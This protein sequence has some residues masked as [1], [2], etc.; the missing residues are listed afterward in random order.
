MNE[1]E[2]SQGI[3]GG[4]FRVDLRQIDDMTRA[5]ARAENVMAYL[6]LARGVNG[7]REHRV[8]THGAHS[9]ATKTGMSNPKAKGALD[10][11]KNPLNEAVPTG[12]IKEYLKPAGAS[13]SVPKKMRPR[14]VMEDPVD[15][16][17]IWLANALTDGI[18]EGKNNPPLMRIYNDVLMGHN[19]SIQEA[20]LDALMVLL[21]LY[22]H[23]DLEA[24][25]G[26]NPRAGIYRTWKSAENSDGERTTDLDDKGS[27]A[28]FEIAGEF[29]SVFTD[30]AAEA[31]FYI[32]DKEE[33]HARFW[34]AFKNLK[35]LGFVY[36]VIQVWDADPHDPK[37]GRSA[38]PLYTLY[39]DD[40]HARE[41]DPYLQKEI[42]VAAITMG[43]M[44]GYF[45][46]SQYSV[47]SNIIGSGRFRYI[48]SKKTRG[49]PIGIYR[50]RFR[51]KTGDTGK[52][53]AAERRRVNEWA[54][55]I[56]KFA[57]G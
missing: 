55:A 54:E 36:E 4:F 15:A 17:D 27:V 8:S 44:E 19:A 20:R 53:M 30:F 47:E 42:H 49:F 1:Q 32:E 51:P 45:E 48:A 9:I 10:W 34:E 46:F 28:L 25:G 5:G 39:V 21:H 2:Q 6:V 29:S 38:E 37:N 33:R 52:G 23:Q 26:I 41:S 43:A 11:L 35:K 13:D 16:Q 56:K 57:A 24:Y 3:K 18:G 22:C 50:L 31:L 12:Y 14:W 40:S 7:S